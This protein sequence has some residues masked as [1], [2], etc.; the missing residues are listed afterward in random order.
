MDVIDKKRNWLETRAIWMGRIQEFI[1]EYSERILIGA[2][3]DIENRNQNIIVR[4]AGRSM[5]FE[6][7]SLA[8]QA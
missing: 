3:I 6:S 5:S 4:N 7:A 1:G 8:A 2:R